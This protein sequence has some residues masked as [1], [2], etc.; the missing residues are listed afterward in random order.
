MHRN[1]ELSGYALISKFSF[2]SDAQE[3]SDGIKRDFV[4]RLSKANSQALY[5]TPS[6]EVS[7]LWAVEM[8]LASGT[9]VTV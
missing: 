4:S 9:T 2:E 1:W 6:E 3:S 7:V 5:Y 8:Y